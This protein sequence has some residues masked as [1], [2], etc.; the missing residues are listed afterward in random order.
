MILGTRVYIHPHAHEDGLSL[1]Q[2]VLYLSAFEMNLR[3]ESSVPVAPGP[4]DDVMAT[5][6]SEQDGISI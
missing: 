1:L 3:W 2:T 4:F 5:W 6:Q